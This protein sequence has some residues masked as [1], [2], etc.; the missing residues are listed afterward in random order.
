MS[1]KNLV[2]RFKGEVRFNRY[3]DNASYS[4][5]RAWSKNALSK[6]NNK[7]KLPNQKAEVEIVAGLNEVLFPVDYALA[8]QEALLAVEYGYSKS[9]TES[10]DFSSNI[11][12]PVIDRNVSKQRQRIPVPVVNTIQLYGV[13]RKALKL[14]LFP[15]ISR[16]ETL[17]Y[18]ANYQVD[19]EGWEITIKDQP[20]PGEDVI[21]VAKNTVTYQFVNS[22]PTNNQVKLGSTSV[23]TAQ[24][25][26]NRIN[27]NK[28]SSGVIAEARGQKVFITGENVIVDTVITVDGVKLFLTHIDAVDN[29]D[30]KVA[31]AH[32][33]WME[34]SYYDYLATDLSSPISDAATRKLFADK[35]VRLFDQALEDLDFTML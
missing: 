27:A 16:T 15:S 34:A 3:E 22:N 1:L 13:S 31:V 33:Q 29:L 4:Q 20:L 32:Y 7:Q 2:E 30:S 8:S 26:A 11:T 19:D 18:Y 25:L 14:H 21:V 10:L 35:A 9:Y 12:Q 5:I 23:F 28:N 17:V 24:N 6:I